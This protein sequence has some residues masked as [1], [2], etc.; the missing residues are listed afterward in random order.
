[1]F[2]L[3]LQPTRLLRTIKTKPSSYVVMDIF[4]PF[5]HKA[6]IDGIALGIDLGTT[7]TLAAYVDESHEVRFIT[8]DNGTVLLPSVIGSLSSTKRFMPQASKPLKNSDKTALDI[9]TEILMIVKQKAQEQSDKEIIHAV[10]TVPA[11]FDDA[12]RQATRVAGER[13]GLTVRRIINEPTAAALAY[14][15]EKEGIYAVY[16]FGGGTFDLSV[17]RM[18]RGIFQVLSTIGDLHLG[19]DDIDAA[20]AQYNS[21]DLIRA[22]ALKEQGTF[23]KSIVA[24]FIERTLK[25]AEKGLR[26]ARVQKLDGVILVGGSTR[27]KG[28]EERLSE[29]FGVSLFSEECPD[30]VVAK[31][32]AIQAYALLHG[33]SH[34]LI[35]VTPLSIGLELMGGVVDKIIPR[36]TPIPILKEQTFTTFQDG[37]TA[38]EFHIVQGERELAADNRSLARFTLTGIDPLPKGHVKIKVKF[39]IDT[40]GLLCVTALNILNNEKIS[41]EIKPTFGLS[42]EDIRSYVLDGQ[43]NARADIENQLWIQKSLEAQQ[44]LDTAL[45]YQCEDASVKQLKSALSTRDLTLL[46]QTSQRVI[47][48]LLPLIEEKINKD[49]KQALVG[50][51]LQDIN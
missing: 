35:D 46:A 18:Q 36:N 50:K 4:D 33:S 20:I 28:L 44:I 10:I 37:Q 34:T 26:D 6:P 42:P 49:L 21:C 13:A 2:K 38:I 9:A 1:M 19:G 23:E 15:I 39:H 8:W 17:L 32:A 27:L 22:K 3:I 16:D 48:Q 7:H 51:L 12:A 5:S 25:L 45:F 41:I 11:Y 47:T 24:P 31:G 43:L 30:T 29:F 40:D 14:G